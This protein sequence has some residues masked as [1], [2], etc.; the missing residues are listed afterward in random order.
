M[1]PE[2]QEQLRAKFKPAQIGKLPKPTKKDNPRGN[3]DFCGGYHGLPAIH[4]DYV[5][6]A[7]VTERVLSVDPDYEFGPVLDVNKR[8]I[9]QQTNDGMEVLYYLTIAGSTKYEWGDGP[10]MKEISS[11]ALRRCAMRFGVALDLWAKEPL[12]LEQD[13][14]AP[15]PK[16]AARAKRKASPT[17]AAAPL[18]NEQKRIVI[19][20]SE[21]SISDD[22]RHRITRML[23][24]HE[25]A[26][27]VAD[28]DCARVAEG[29]RFFAE[30]PQS[31]LAQLE[32]WEEEN[33][34]VA[35]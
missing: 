29:I 15:A 17:P 3:C 16:P 26:R 21:A 35:A 5:G 18:T 31:A 9:T 34:V 2:Q 12:N 23:T 14:D 10:N 28:A 25:S 8:P 30:F 24:G 33:G 1:T 4:L 7:A 19:A 22:L 13:A 27:D 6:H 20:A 11:D 32:Q